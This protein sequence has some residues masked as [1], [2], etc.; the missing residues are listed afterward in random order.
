MDSLL[1]RMG[2]K[3]FAAE[4]KLVQVGLQFSPAAKRHPSGRPARPDHLAV[5]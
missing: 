2:E 5:N 4:Y 1:D 3:N